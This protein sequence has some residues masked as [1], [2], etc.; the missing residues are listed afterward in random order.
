MPFV[1]SPSAHS[2]QPDEFSFSRLHH[3]S[4]CMACL[5]DP[6]PWQRCIA[7]LPYAPPWSDLITTFKYQ[8]EAGL[9]RFLAQ[10]M[11]GC[12]DIQHLISQADWLLPVPLSAQR[13]RER[14]FNQSLLLAQLLSPQKTR[15]DALHRLRHTLSQAG[16]TRAD[17]LHNLAHAFACNARHMA[18]L[19]AKR[20]VLV[21]DVLTTGS[22]L[23]ACTQTLLA[24]GVTQ[25]DCIVLAR[26]T[27]EQAPQS[28]ID[29]RV[30]HVQHRSGSA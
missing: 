5:M 30:H 16:M 19:Q 26:A 21:D 29:H 8:G 13:L 3:T 17:R 9:V 7:A 18:H 23:K 10:Q 1:A 6:P 11:G 20:V 22:T 28:R 24:A 2:R 15:V 12:E 4:S 27:G 14:G 25:V